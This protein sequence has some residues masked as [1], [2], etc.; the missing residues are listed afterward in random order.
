MGDFTVDTL[1]VGPLGANCY[2]VT[3][4][5]TKDACLIDPGGEPERIKLFLKKNGLNVKFIINTHGHGDH[6]LGNGYFNVPIYIHRLEKD[7]LTDPGL[8]LSGAFGLALKTPK[9]SR[10]LEDGEKVYLNDLEF[11]ILHTPGHTPGGISVKLDG[12]IFTGDSLFAGSVGRTDLPDG[13]QQV[14]LEAIRKKIFTLDDDTVVYPGH[15][16]ESTVGIEKGTN[17]F[18]R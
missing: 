7:F 16:W 2:I 9:A 5:P 1:S 14:L 3:H 15:G 12:V 18:F 10:L 4:V 11:E 13:N 17:P 6:I 8:N